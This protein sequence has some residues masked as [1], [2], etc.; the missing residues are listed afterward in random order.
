MA[1][2]GAAYWH[3]P[4]SPARSYRSSGLALIHT[5]FFNLDC[6]LASPCLSPRMC[7]VQAAWSYVIGLEHNSH[8]VL[9]H[10]HFSNGNYS[11]ASPACKSHHRVCPT[12]PPPP[13]EMLCTPSSSQGTESRG[14]C[15]A[16]GKGQFKI[17]GCCSFESLIPFQVA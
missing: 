16:P 9:I 8:L 12:A 15:A 11:H 10:M 17:L 14:A 6:R 13:K 1:R 3:K 5:H 4:L 2:P 7:G